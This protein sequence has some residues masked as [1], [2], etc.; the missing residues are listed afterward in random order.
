MSRLRSTKCRSP[1]DRCTLESRT[2]KIRDQF[3]SLYIPESLKWD[4]VAYIAASLGG[5]RMASHTFSHFLRE[6]GIPENYINELVEAATRL[7]YAQVRHC[8]PVVLQPHSIQPRTLTI[9]THCKAPF[10]WIRMAS[11]SM[12]GFNKYLSNSSVALDQE[13][14]LTQLYVVDVFYSLACPQILLSSRSI[15][16]AP[17]RRLH[18]TGRSA[19]PPAR[20]IIRLSS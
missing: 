14:C 9:S 4:N 17:S 3:A 18:R 7:N 13:Y 10:L 12:A 11:A 8:I 2:K 20:W 19:V 15:V 1:V 16:S 5:T 6:N